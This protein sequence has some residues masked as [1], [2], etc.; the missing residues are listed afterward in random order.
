M[1][2]NLPKVYLDFI[3]ECKGKDYGELFTHKHHIIPKFM[4]GTNERDNLIVLSVENHFLAHKILAENCDD[5][6]KAG[7]LKASAYLLN[8]YP[9]LVISK[10]E[11]SKIHSIATKEYL[12]YNPPQR[13]GK[14]GYKHTKNHSINL[15][16]SLKNFYKKNDVWNK[17]KQCENI[18]IALKKWY[19]SNDNPFKNKKHSE[20]TKHKMKQNHTDFSGSKNP[21]SKK[22]IDLETGIVYGCIKDMANDIGVP[23]TTMNRWVK[24]Y[25]KERFKYISYE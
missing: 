16:I 12:K 2:T 11:I 13:L 23:R 7:N 9:N 24:D 3:Q 4:G 25:K 8:R 18:S 5:V 6:Y 1:K 17:G 15:S 22:C 14:T 21:S 19:D 10:D 20:N